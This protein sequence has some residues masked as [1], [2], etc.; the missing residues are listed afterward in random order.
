VFLHFTLFYNAFSEMFL[1]RADR[2]SEKAN[3]CSSI[4][5]HRFILFYFIAIYFCVIRLMM[6][7]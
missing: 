6:E 7:M 3:H 4:L 1:L 2:F 5:K